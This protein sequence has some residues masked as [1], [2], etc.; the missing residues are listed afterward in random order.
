MQRLCCASI[1][2]LACAFSGHARAAERIALVV[3][4]A[5]YN[6]KGWSLTTP[7]NDAKAVATA[8]D[9]VGFTTTVLLSPRRG[10][11]E[12]EIAELATA[13]E[14]AGPDSV[15]LVYYSGHGAQVYGLNFL[16]PSDADLHSEQD[17]YRDGV[18]LGEVAL[19]LQRAGNRVNFIV[20]DA[21]RNNP[22]PSLYRG[23]QGGL[24]NEQKVRGMLFAYATSPGN[25]AADGSGA[26][27]PYTESFVNNITTPGIVSETA[28]R[29]I[30]T[31]VEEKTHG[32]Q[33]PW[34][35]SA[36]R[37]AD[38]CFAS[39]PKTEPTDPKESEAAS[40]YFSGPTIATA[41]EAY[42][43]LKLLTFVWPATPPGNVKYSFGELS[44]MGKNFG[45]N[46]ETHTDANA[47][48][49]SEGRV[50]AVIEGSKKYGNVVVIDHDRNI[51]TIYTHLKKISTKK[52]KTVNA[53]DIIGKIGHSGGA[54]G[55]QLHFEVHFRGIPLDP[56]RINFSP[57]L[58]YFLGGEYVVNRVRYKP[59]LDAGY[60]RIGIAS[61]YGPQFHG[62]KTANGET[63]D[64]NKLSA[65]HPTLPLPS[66]V[67]VENLG[68]GRI[69]EVRVNDRGPF[70]QGRLIDLSRAAADAL[71]FLDVGTAKVRVRFK[72]LADIDMNA[73]LSDGDRG[74]AEE[75]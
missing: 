45:I 38:F 7:E 39:C 72:E 32:L 66:I 12:A 68:N 18:R 58:S 27:S 65:A 21:C 40:P 71:G 14:E 60:D 61:W 73:T 8:L 46:I 48:S 33:V 49:S 75:R 51:S 2:F 41:M 10:K 13:L 50:A 34:V 54:A 43:Q 47:L 30:A 52:G 25:T 6:Q 36:L 69:I 22:L 16:I 1:F 59:E 64:M 62:R 3:G 11:L 57:A 15:G 42:E 74:E 53:G 23:K 24:S 44:P 19:R 35:E 4:I 20:L 17:F 29:R 9:S 67:T 26:L 31:D 70:S 56:E 63:Y 55:E 5:D 28:F 37:G